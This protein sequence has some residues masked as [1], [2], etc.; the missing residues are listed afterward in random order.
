[1]VTVYKATQNPLTHL[2]C[3]FNESPIDGHKIVSNLFFFFN[4]SSPYTGTV[5]DI[6]EVKSHFVSRIISVGSIPKL[7]SPST[8][9]I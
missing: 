8:C 5:K 2:C 1:M 7:E 6:L 3:S 4:Y 9:T